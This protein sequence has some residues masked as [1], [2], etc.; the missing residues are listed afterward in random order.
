MGDRNQMWGAIIALAVPIILLLFLWAT[1]TETGRQIRSQG[2]PAAVRN[3]G[4]EQ[5]SSSG[6][7][8]TTIADIVTPSNIFLGVMAALVL[9]LLWRDIRE[10]RNTGELHAFVPFLLVAVFISGVWLYGTY[11]LTHGAVF[12]W[13]L[14]V[15]VT[16]LLLFVWR[17]V[18]LNRQ[19][20]EY[21]ER[22]QEVDTTPIYGDAGIA[23]P[24]DEREA[25]L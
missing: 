20:E 13:P 2:I 7:N 16:L 8:D 15:L 11:F 9:G 21:A 14:A 3:A 24:D 18:S 22:L 1:V 17:V 19:R 10:Y 23:T 12:V 5:Q 6:F 4:P 25:G